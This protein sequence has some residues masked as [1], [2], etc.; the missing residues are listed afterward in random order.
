MTA[1]PKIIEMILKTEVSDSTGTINGILVRLS[2]V[3][4]SHLSDKRLT[5]TVVLQRSVMAKPTKRKVNTRNVTPLKTRRNV[6]AHT[7]ADSRY[8]SKTLNTI[9]LGYFHPVHM[10]FV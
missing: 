6:T 8:S 3:K 10:L 9:F 2:P 5:L 7:G 4:D 1:L